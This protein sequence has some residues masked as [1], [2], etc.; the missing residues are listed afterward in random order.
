MCLFS[1]ATDWWVEE[2]AT[3]KVSI[4]PLRERCLLLEVTLD[5]REVLLLQSIMILLISC[6]EML[7]VIHCIEGTCPTAPHGVSQDLSLIVFTAS[8]V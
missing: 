6:S 2:H 7:I 5:G 4:A 3:R 1:N 8:C